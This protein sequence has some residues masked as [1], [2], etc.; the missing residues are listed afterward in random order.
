MP[1]REFQILRQ[2]ERPLTEAAWFWLMIWRAPTPAA[3]AQSGWYREVA[4]RA[5]EAEMIDTMILAISTL[6]G[7]FAL[8][9]FIGCVIV[10]ICLRKR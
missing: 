2:S 9:V 10:V 8:G 6:Y 1:K 4:N 5:D 7:G 3:R